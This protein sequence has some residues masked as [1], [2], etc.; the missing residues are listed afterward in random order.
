[1]PTTRP[2]PCSCASTA[3]PASSGLAGIRAVTAIAGLAVARPLLGW[4]R[5]ELAEIVARRRPR[6]GRRSRATSTTASTAPA[7]ASSSPSADW[8]DPLPLARSAEALAEAEAALDWTAERLIEERVEPRRRASRFDPAGL[9]AELRRRL[10]L[11]ILAALVPAEPPRGEALQRL[12]ATLEA[13]GTATLAGIK[14]EGGPVWRFAPAPP[15]R[16]APSRRFAR[17]SA[18]SSADRKRERSAL[19]NGAGPPPIPSAPARRSAM[20]ARVA[21]ARADRGGGERPAVGRDH[22]RRARLQAAVG[23]QDVA[24]HHHRAGPAPRSAIQSSAASNA[25]E[26]GH[27][28]DQRMLGHPSRWLL[29]IRTGT[30]CRQA[31]LYTSSFT[32]QASAS[33][34]MIGPAGRSL[35]TPF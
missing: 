10:V 16:A 24:G 3:A 12:L 18:S 6:A 29:T 14:C 27:P 22:R 35:I 11:R 21:I 33:T 7:C 26:T 34:R 5:A 15:R 8:L 4:R 13:G 23:E 1:M 2:R 19:A 28:L 30:P 20:I 32:G 17:T 25:S 9:P 31:T